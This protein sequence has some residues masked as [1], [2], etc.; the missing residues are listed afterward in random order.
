MLS[1]NLFTDSLYVENSRE[2]LTTNKI[3]L[4]LDFASSV[5]PFANGDNKFAI[6]FYFRPNIGNLAAWFDESGNPTDKYYSIH[7][8][9][10]HFDYDWL[11]DEYPNLNFNFSRL[12][13]SFNFNNKKGCLF[14]SDL[15]AT[16]SETLLAAKNHQLNYGNWAK[17]VIPTICLNND[18]WNQITVVVSLDYND[19]NALV[20]KN[21]YQEIY[22]NFRPQP[23]AA[24]QLVINALFEYKNYN[25]NNHQFDYQKSLLK[26]EL[27]FT[28]YNK[29]NDPSI[30]SLF[31]FDNN[32]NYN[33]EDY[34]KYPHDIITKID[35]LRT[36]LPNPNLILP[37]TTY[38]LSSTTKYNFD[39]IT[40]YLKYRDHHFYHY[41][42][43]NTMY[44][45]QKQ[46]VEITDNVGTNNRLLIDPFLAHDELVLQTVIP[47]LGIIIN[48]KIVF[49]HHNFHRSVTISIPFQ[50]K[51]FFNNFINPQATI[52]LINNDRLAYYYNQPF[53]DNQYANFVQDFYFQ[54]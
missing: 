35:K 41:F 22:W 48:Q 26:D 46:R 20:A 31:S 11:F 53:D 27:T 29:I 21:S 12:T 17:E 43:N 38:I 54:N 7:N 6:P 15:L 2:F 32:F 44:N 45:P 34:K 5:Y 47:T 40:G 30:P 51:S 25:E 1:T 49:D 24:S 13:V 9:H 19:N 3:N 39:K 33:L 37:V 50:K 28:Y 42:S 8:H 23:V 36:K 18:N 52:F 14:N 4:A 16:S 10:P